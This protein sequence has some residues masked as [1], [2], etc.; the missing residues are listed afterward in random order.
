[1]DCF[2]VR[3]GGENGKHAA[4][5]VVIEQL[6]RED[7]ESWDPDRRRVK[8]FDTETEAVSYAVDHLRTHFRTHHQPS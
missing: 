1:M 6:H 2:E 7:L 3:K 5:W 4:R 8:D